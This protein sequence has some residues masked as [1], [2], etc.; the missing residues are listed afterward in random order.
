[1]YYFVV[2]CIILLVAATL[3]ALIEM[4]PHLLTFIFLSVP[5]IGAAGYYYDLF[6][7]I[8]IVFIII[9]LGGAISSLGIISTFKANRYFD[10]D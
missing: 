6:P 10:W 9:G 7:K 4:T 3:V 8:I 1:M 5:A 2:I